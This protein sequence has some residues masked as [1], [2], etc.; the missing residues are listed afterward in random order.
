MIF[1]IH[2]IKEKNN[3]SFMIFLIHDIKEKKK[4]KKKF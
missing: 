3:N 4:K 1:L 2:D